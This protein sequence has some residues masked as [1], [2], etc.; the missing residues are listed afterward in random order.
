MENS[1]VQIP[2]EAA[3][4]EPESTETHCIRHFGYLNERSSKEKIPE[5]CMMCTE[6]LRCMSKT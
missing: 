5:D 1:G 3:A 4:E 6:I 2:P